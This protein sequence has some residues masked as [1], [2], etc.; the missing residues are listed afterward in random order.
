MSSALLIRND[1]KVPFEKNSECESV[2]G[3]MISVFGSMVYEI[4][5]PVPFR[6]FFSLSVPPMWILIHS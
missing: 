2:G 1:R 6:L 3:K 4:L 5:A